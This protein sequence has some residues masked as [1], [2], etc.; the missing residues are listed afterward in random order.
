MRLG[1]VSI[2]SGVMH[3]REKRVAFVENNWKAVGE[4]VKK[5]VEEELKDEERAAKAEIEAA[6]E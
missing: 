1:P 5:Q 3:E 4:L 6:R 2:T